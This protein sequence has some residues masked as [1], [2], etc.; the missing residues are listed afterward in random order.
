MSRVKE[1]EVTLAFCIRLEGA[2][3]ATEFWVRGEEVQGIVYW[4][5]GRIETVVNTTL[6]HFIKKVKELRDGRERP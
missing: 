5:S 3:S 1:P 6:D 4:P 2:H